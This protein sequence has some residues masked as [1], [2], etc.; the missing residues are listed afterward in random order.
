MNMKNATWYFYAACFLWGF[1]GSTAGL[2]ISVLVI[3]F[4]VMLLIASP[5]FFMAE[6]LRHFEIETKKSRHQKMDG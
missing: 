1:F 5:F 4:L 2:P 6:L 3:G